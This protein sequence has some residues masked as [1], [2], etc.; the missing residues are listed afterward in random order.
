[1]ETATPVD[2]VE[3]GSD[4]DSTLRST[5]VAHSIRL[6]ETEAGV[7]ELLAAGHSNRR[8]CLELFLAQ[9][10]IDYHLARLRRKLHA[11]SRA[12]IVSRAY[13]LGFLRPAE[14]PP[15]VRRNANDPDPEART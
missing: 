14:W 12:A 8:I 10:T 15:K 9:P 13:A 3:R 5:V 2:V 11:P 1:V 7:L 6:T 4:A